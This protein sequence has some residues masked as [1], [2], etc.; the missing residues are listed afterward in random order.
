M[1]GSCTT[2]VLCHGNKN[3]PI[4]PPSNSQYQVGVSATPSGRG[5]V[6]HRAE[7]GPWKQPWRRGG[8]FLC[9]SPDAASAGGVPRLGEDPLRRAGTAGAWQPI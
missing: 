4:F 6:R 3:C 9:I 7:G 2:L 8:P 5:G 1:H